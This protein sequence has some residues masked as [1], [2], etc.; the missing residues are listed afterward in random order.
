MMNNKT[1]LSH[2][3]VNSLIIDKLGKYPDDVR[4]IATMTIEA[5]ERLPEQAVAD[6]LVTL[7]RN[8]TRGLGG[9]DQ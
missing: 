8:E 9:D 6:Q 3:N 1:S 4:R 7:I 2:S 5:S